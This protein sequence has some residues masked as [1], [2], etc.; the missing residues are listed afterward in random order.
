MDGGAAF[1]FA[2]FYNIE[3]CN[4]QSE[5]IIGKIFTT[6]LYK[7]ICFATFM[8]A[9]FHRL[10]NALD[11]QESP[12]SDTIDTDLQFTKRGMDY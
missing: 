1:N 8:I 5:V 11:G 10:H 3:H 4:S 7:Y 6:K 2:R 9:F 12:L